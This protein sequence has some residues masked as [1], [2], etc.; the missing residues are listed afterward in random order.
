[1][2][3]REEKPISLF[4][5]LDVCFVFPLFLFLVKHEIFSM[6]MVSGQIKKGCV[7]SQNYKPCLL[8]VHPITG[9]NC[10][11]SLLELICL[12]NVSVVKMAISTLNWSFKGIFRFLQLQLCVSVKYKNAGL[13]GLTLSCT[14]SYLC[15]VHCQACEWGHSH[16]SQVA[17]V[18]CYLPLRFLKVVFLL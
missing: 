12:I 10:N 16:H 1:M 14:S 11:F 3:V 8:T 13:F 4:Y 7:Y 2:S 15:L 5:I 18:F 17:D 6:L 9:P